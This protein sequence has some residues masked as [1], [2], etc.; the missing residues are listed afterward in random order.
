[1]IVVSRG[2]RKVVEVE[3]VAEAVRAGLVEAEATVEVGKRTE[4]Q[5]GKI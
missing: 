4:E 3:V 1:M 5:R 2:I